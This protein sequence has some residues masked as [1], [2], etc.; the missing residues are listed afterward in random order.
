M[1]KF[2]RTS[3]HRAAAAVAT[4][5]ALA[6]GLMTA[7]ASMAGTAF[8]ARMSSVIEHVKADP[9]YKKIPLNTSGDREWFFDESKALYDKKITKEQ[10]LADGNKQFP[11]YE[12]SFSELA[13]LITAS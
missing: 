5:A 7:T 4:A 2:Q 9:G 12:A 6:A 3:I 8:D 11:G 10:Y 13:D 1:N